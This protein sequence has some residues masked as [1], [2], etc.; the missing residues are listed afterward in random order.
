[1]QQEALSQILV[2]D[3]CPYLRKLSLYRPYL[4]INEKTSW[5]ST[6]TENQTAI[7]YVPEYKDWA[8]GD[9]RKIGGKERLI[10]STENLNKEEAKKWNL[11]PTDISG[12]NWKYYDNGW[13]KPI[14]K[15]DILVKCVDT[16]CPGFVYS[17]IDYLSESFDLR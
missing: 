14:E 3:F 7:W 1:M 8:I 17:K 10:T 9:V 15:W 6:S 2:S 12:E 13:K 16:V 4:T 11:S 5:I